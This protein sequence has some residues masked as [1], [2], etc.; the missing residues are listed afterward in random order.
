M[1]SDDYERYI[2]EMR[3]WADK[4]ETS[5]K[6]QN[7]SFRPLIES[8]DGMRY[9]YRRTNDLLSKLLDEVRKNRAHK[10]KTI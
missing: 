9:E 8:I 7:Q 1:F 10:K 4:L 2:K 6:M 3:Y 5:Y